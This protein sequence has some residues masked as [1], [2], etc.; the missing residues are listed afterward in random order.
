MAFWLFKE[1]PSTY[2]FAQLVQDGSTFWSGVHNALAQ[3]YL[4]QV[5]PGDRVWFYAT[6]NLKAIVGEM[7]VIDEPKPDPADATGKTYGV[8]VRPVRPLALPLTLAEIKA[9]PRF[10]QWELVRLPRLS[11]MPVPEE[12]WQQIAQKTQAMPASPPLANPKPSRQRKN[13]TS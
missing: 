12:V 4:R 9:D 11:V 13:S 6:G 8:T 5:R 7:E 2:S 3:K 10:A 1:E